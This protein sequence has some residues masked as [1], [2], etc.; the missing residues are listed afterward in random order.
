MFR[1]GNRSV[2]RRRVIPRLS[3]AERFASRIAARHAFRDMD[4]APLTLDVLMPTGKSGDEAMTLNLELLL[5]IAHDSSAARLDRRVALAT[6]MR[7][8]RMTEHAGPPRSGAETRAQT[9]FASR[10]TGTAGKEGYVA[11]DKSE[12]AGK[13]IRRVSPE[14]EK[15]GMKVLALHASAAV[16]AKRFS[17]PTRETGAERVWMQPVM[18]LR[19]TTAALPYAEERVHARRI[20]ANAPRR[21]YTQ[22]ALD[23]A[24]EGSSPKL[25]G[26]GVTRDGTVARR[27]PDTLMMSR[28]AVGLSTQGTQ[29]QAAERHETGAGIGF[30]TTV[31]DTASAATRSVAR[32]STRADIARV[33][34]ASGLLQTMDGMQTAY[35]R[36]E[37]LHAMVSLRG[38]RTG[39]QTLPGAMARQHGR[40]AREIPAGARATEPQWGAVRRRAGTRLQGVVDIANAEGN[41]FFSGEKGQADVRRARGA[42]DDSRMAVSDIFTGMRGLMGTRRVW[43]AAD[44]QRSLTVVNTVRDAAP[45][46]VPTSQARANARTAPLRHVPSAQMWAGDQPSFEPANAAG[47]VVPR[48]VLNSLRR[49]NAR[50]EDLRL[51]PGAPRRRDD[52][53][54]Y[55]AADA[56]GVVASRFVLNSQKRVNARA[57]DLRLAPGAPR[58]RDGQRA[59]SAADAA[60]VAASRFVPGARWRAN[61]RAETSLLATDALGQ[62]HTQRAL[63]IA[64]GNR[65]DAFRMIPSSQRRAV[66]GT[67][68]SPF[69]PSIQRRASAQRTQDASDAAREVA[70]RPASS[71]QMQ[72]RTRLARETADAAR[73]V[74]S[75]QTPGAPRPTD[76]RNAQGSAADARTPDYRNAATSQ[77][78]YGVRRERDA[79]DARAVGSHHA[80][81]AETGAVGRAQNA[82][83]DVRVGSRR[84]P[85][86]QIPANGRA[87]RP[88]D[89]FAANPAVDKPVAARRTLD[90]AEAQHRETAPNPLNGRY[91]ADMRLRTGHAADAAR[92]AGDRSPSAPVGS[93]QASAE[94]TRAPESRGNLRSAL[95]AGGVRSIQNQGMPVDIRHPERAAQEVRSAVRSGSPSVNWRAGLRTISGSVGGQAS[96]AASAAW[97]DE[98]SDSA[99]ESGIAPYPVRRA[100]TRGIASLP[101]V[102]PQSRRAV[103]QNLAANAG[104]SAA[105]GDAPHALGQVQPIAARAESSGVSSAP[106]SPL[107][108]QERGI[109]KDLI[110]AKKAFATSHGLTAQPSPR[111]VRARMTLSPVEIRVTAGQRAMR[112]ATGESRGVAHIS[113]RESGARGYADRRARLPNG[114]AE[115]TWVQ[116]APK[117]LAAGTAPSAVRTAHEGNARPQ[118]QDVRRQPARRA[119]ESRLRPAGAPQGERGAR[120]QAGMSKTSS[121]EMRH[122]VAGHSA[123]Q[124]PAQTGEP[125][126]AHDPQ[127]ARKQVESAVRQTASRLAG[128]DR[129]SEPEVDRIVRRVMGEVEKR[130]KLEA[131]RRGHI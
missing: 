28:Q 69:V 59:L 102:I 68:T 3:A 7:V 91:R 8:R 64:D 84:V 12:V 127:G 15:S 20:A 32:R 60:G 67:N 110:S 122:R 4:I 17:A 23:E 77:T 107:A 47:V 94:G 86:A 54:A 75:R 130:V 117:T 21:P 16:S 88:Q 10:G 25:R 27:L 99:V 98:R 74:I 14:P 13:T 38:V 9:G 5:R 72:V 105:P 56:V 104:G 48:Y 62:A 113:I 44:V 6:A 81:N 93:P 124:P 123:E 50:A 22:L 58:R 106:L 73:T 70:S 66:I 41:V 101:G 29:A 95:E 103:M 128:T 36:M 42:A 35:G 19:G 116:S 121:A 78:Q 83:E 52:Q 109:Q 118:E 51:A 126:A 125:A 89:A 100:S 55:S 46:L 30:R 76:A 63:D 112:L 92:K 2:A 53:R 45:R 57:E 43:E 31:R 114:W 11:R 65:S 40:V 80:P 82:A 61:V 90:L 71:M 97:T 79:A 85:S 24:G 49:V 39:N 131:L 129:V 87:Q 96:R 18:A 37:T 119:A 33:R 111:T 115:R 34:S 108:Q 1:V 120:V 26:A